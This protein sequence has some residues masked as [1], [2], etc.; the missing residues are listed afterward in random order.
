M[1]KF[2][3]YYTML[4]KFTYTNKVIYD[5]SDSQGKDDLINHIINIDP[6]YNYARFIYLLTTKGSIRK[7]LTQKK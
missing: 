5:I 3:T 2:N 7:I 1:T 6:V 4:K